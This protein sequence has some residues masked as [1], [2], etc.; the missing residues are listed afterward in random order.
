MEH[1]ADMQKHQVLAAL[2]EAI[3]D[4][5]KASRPAELPGVSCDCI[6]TNKINAHLDPNY[7][8]GKNLH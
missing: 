6:I 5:I 4:C 8:H 2:R 3:V 1:L 7:K